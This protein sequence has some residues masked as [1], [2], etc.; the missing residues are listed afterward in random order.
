M[1]GMESSHDSFET[2]Q[3]SKSLLMQKLFYEAHP[4]SQALVKRDTTEHFLNPPVYS[5]MLKAESSLQQNS[6]N[7]SQPSLE[8]DWESSGKF[9]NSGL[10][11]LSVKKERN[12][13]IRDGNENCSAGH[14][15]HR[16]HTY[17]CI[18]QA[19]ANSAIKQENG[20]ELETTSMP[21]NWWQPLGRVDYIPQGISAASNVST[22]PKFSSDLSFPLASSFCSCCQRYCCHIHS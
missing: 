20:Q 11:Q 18:A 17:A 14:L 1:Q 8:M 4:T 12:V 2:E 3:D 16:D 13:I 22:F 6:D 15:D 5:E 10:P 9:L 19:K 7:S 21:S